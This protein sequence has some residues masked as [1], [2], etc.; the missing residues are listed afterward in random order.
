MDGLEIRGAPRNAQVCPRH[1][2]F[3]PGNKE[4]AKKKTLLQG[5]LQWLEGKDETGVRG[6]IT[7]EKSPLR[8][9]QLAL[10][11]AEDSLQQ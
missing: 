7:L 2:R 4:K 11:L 1:W 8:V 3:R 5:F 9:Y 6:E 10:R